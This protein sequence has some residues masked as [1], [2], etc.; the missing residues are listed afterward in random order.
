MIARHWR[1]LARAAAAEDYVRHLQ[2][3]TFPAIRRLPGFVSAAILRRAVPEGVEFLV[4]THWES[5]AAI[6]AFAGDAVETAVVPQVVRDMM[7]DYDHSVRHYE[8]VP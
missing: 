5:L 4:V 6:R 7:L 1:G 2:E 8:V 3:E